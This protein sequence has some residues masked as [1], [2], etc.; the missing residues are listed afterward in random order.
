MFELYA[1]HNQLTLR[2]REPMTSGLVNVCQVRFEFSEDW[3][4]LT[5]TAIFKAGLESRSVPLG[6]D[7]VCAIPWEVLRMPKYRLYAGVR[8]TRDGGI[9]LPTVWSDLGE[10][11]PGAASSGETRPPTPELWEQALAGKG[12]ALK[13]DGLNLSLMS[14]ER[15]LD[16]VRI[17]GGGAPVPGPPGPKGEK[18]DPGEQGPAGAAGKDAVINGENTL[19]LLAGD[20][21]IL[22]QQGSR[23][24]ISTNSHAVDGN[25]VG[26]IISFMGTNTKL[27]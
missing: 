10:I 26:T 2:K 25:P 6:E 21:I 18:G 24:T 9:V 20:N 27:Q 17:E 16:T 19:E 22:E 3:D 13:C 7:G 12:D 14:G 4:G 11:L 1:N 5:R 8:G 15:A 23:M